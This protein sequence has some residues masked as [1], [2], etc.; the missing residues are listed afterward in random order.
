LIIAI[1]DKSDHLSHPETD[2]L[3]FI[4]PVKIPLA[5]RKRGRLPGPF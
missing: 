5:Q 3:S 2:N 1:M 4:A